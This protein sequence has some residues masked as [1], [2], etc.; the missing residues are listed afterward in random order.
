MNL[1]RHVDKHIVPDEDWGLSERHFAMLKV[2]PGFCS[3]ELA[4]PC[5][6]IC[7]G[8]ILNRKTCHGS[9]LEGPVSMSHNDLGACWHVVQ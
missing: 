6:P 9:L 5:R 2:I 4:C 8:A 3:R 1:Y 7:H